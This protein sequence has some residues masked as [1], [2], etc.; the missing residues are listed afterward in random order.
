LPFLFYSHK[1]HK[2]ENYFIFEK[3]KKKIWA[4]LKI[5]GLGSGIRDPRSGIRKKT[6]PDPGV[7]KALDSGSQIRISNT[8]A[9][10]IKLLSGLKEY[11]QNK[12]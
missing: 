12:I 11:L 3:L 4:D 2:I 6:F 10:L 7:K 1:L 8:A 5:L 9:F